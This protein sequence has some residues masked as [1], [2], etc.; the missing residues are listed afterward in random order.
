[1]SRLQMDTLGEM[2]LHAAG[3]CTLVIPLSESVDKGLKLS[4]LDY[5]GMGC[6]AVLIHTSKRELSPAHLVCP[7]RHNAYVQ[8]P[9]C[10]FDVNLLR[11]GL[12]LRKPRG[13]DPSF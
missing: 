9:R 3:N 11:L 10:H 4:A 2:R 6:V 7:W 12:L 8:S 5:W 13:V 1:M